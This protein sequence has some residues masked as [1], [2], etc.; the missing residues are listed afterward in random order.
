MYAEAVPENHPAGHIR[1]VQPS[2]N[3][4]LIDL[5]PSI[6]SFCKALSTVSVGGY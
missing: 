1:I 5:Y 3:R 4:W 6:P 2:W